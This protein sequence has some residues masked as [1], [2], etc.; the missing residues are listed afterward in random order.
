[1]KFFF[2]MT[3]IMLCNAVNAQPIPKFGEIDTA[4]MQ[5]NRCEFDPEAPAV[6][7]FDNGEF[8]CNIVYNSPFPTQILNERHV[9][10]KI[11]NDK[12]LDAANVH[13]RYYSFKGEERVIGIAAQTYNMDETGK[14]TVTKL[15]KK[16]IY[17]K[18][19][20]KRFSETVF[21][22]PDVKAG[23]I[24]EYKYTIS[25]SDDGRWY[26]QQEY[27]VQLSKYT[28]NFPNELEMTLMP[29]CTLPYTRDV[30]RRSGRDV[31]V[32][33]MRNVPGLRNEPYISCREDF[34]QRAD[35]RI[36]AINPIGSPRRSLVRS[37][38]GIIRNLIED[39]DFG[40]QLKKEIPRT[41]QLDSILKGISDTFLR[42][43]AIHDYVRSNMEWDGQNSIWALDGVKSAWKAK[44][45]NSGEINLILVNLLKD[46]GLNAHPILVSTRKNGKVNTFYPNL[47][48][49]DK[50]LAFVETDRGYY[51]LDGTDKF[52]PSSLI[53][54]EVV[55]TQGLV[56]EKF[57][58]FQWG[59]PLII[60]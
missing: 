44:K 42:I 33:S 60:S 45:G 5:L 17:N 53:P 3:S 32:I 36:I 40:V 55:A 6:V 9:R 1:M 51:V 35:A 16:L 49:F 2:F 14:I 43:S 41:T 52:T 11:L 26:F 24:I 7:L 38:Q 4:E 8:Y 37:W 31:Q 28:L 23:S 29:S 56:I 25:G 58:S 34:L 13:I 12:G 59:W 18:E 54:A 20:N 15:D 57:D 19:I 50:V 39:D 30:E 10:I 48:Q 22:L 21:T 47:N 27:P 46:A